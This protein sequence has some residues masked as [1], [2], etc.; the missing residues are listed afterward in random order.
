MPRLSHGTVFTL[1]E[2]QD[3][4]DAVAE[5]AAEIP[6]GF[7]VMTQPVDTQDFGF[8]FSG[9]QNDPDNL[10]PEGRATPSSNSA[11]PCKIL[12]DPPAEGTRTFQLPTPTSGSSWIT[13]SPS[14]WSRRSCLIS[15]PP[16]SPR[17]GRPR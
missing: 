14:N 4:R 2:F 11:A 12:V 16:T 5:R 17:L 6:L 10:L 3:A 15:W 8:L 1:E 13:T 9:L 7:A